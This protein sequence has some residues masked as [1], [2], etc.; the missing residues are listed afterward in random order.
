MG[1][2]L[3]RIGRGRRCG[4]VARRRRPPVTSEAIEHQEDVTEAVEIEE[5]I[6]PRWPIIVGGS[7]IIRAAQGDGGMPPVGESD[8]EIGIPSATKADDLD[9]LAA[10]RMMGMGDGDE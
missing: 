1:M 9:L 3:A 7:Q 2:I 8:D 10:E 5:V 6:G 4:V